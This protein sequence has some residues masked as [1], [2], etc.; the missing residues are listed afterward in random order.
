MAASA[1]VSGNLVPRLRNGQ[2]GMV[3]SEQKYLYRKQQQVVAKGLFFVLCLAVLIWLK[4]MTQVCDVHLTPTS[5]RDWVRQY[6][7]S[8]LIVLRTGANVT[9]GHDICTY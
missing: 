6:S 4:V 1:F 3:D 5:H 2:D 7:F 8:G 9:T